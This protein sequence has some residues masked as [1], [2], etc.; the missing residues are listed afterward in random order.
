MMINWAKKQAP[1]TVKQLEDVLDA[2]TQYGL[3][4]KRAFVE[5][6]DEPQQDNL[7]YCKR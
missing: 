5:S 7:G 2:M 4:A 1:K 3:R 6:E